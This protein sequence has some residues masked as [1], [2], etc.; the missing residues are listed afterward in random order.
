MEYLAV[1]YDIHIAKKE[2][3][4]K[5]DYPLLAEKIEQLEKN[6]HPC[7]ELHEFDVWPSLNARIELLERQV[8]ELKHDSNSN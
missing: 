8:Q 4:W 2:A 5:S 7:K 1:K 3:K 6:S